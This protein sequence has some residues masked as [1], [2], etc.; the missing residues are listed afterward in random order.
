MRPCETCEHYTERDGVKGCS[1]W[2]CDKDDNDE[3]EYDD[4][5]R[6]GEEWR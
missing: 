5:D 2:E 4:F 6:T 1:A 3:K